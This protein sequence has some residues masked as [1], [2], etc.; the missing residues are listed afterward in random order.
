MQPNYILL[1][2]TSSFLFPIL[3]SYRKNNMILFYSSIIAFAGSMNYWR[4][5]SLIHNRKLDLVTSKLSLICYLVYGYTNIQWISLKAIGY[6]NLYM[7]YYF[8]N[9]SC[10]KYIL[11]DDDWVNDHML[12]HF[13]TTFAKLYV[14]HWS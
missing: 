8:Y 4:N 1:G 13:Y 14:I 12:F 11:N 3:Y 7:L 2:S 6:A 9:S 5:P 10:K